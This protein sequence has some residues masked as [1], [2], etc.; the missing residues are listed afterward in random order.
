M[1]VKLLLA[2]GLAGAILFYFPSCSKESADR[3]AGACDTTNVSYAQI[4]SI[5][6]SNCY[7][8][9]NGANS[10]SGIDLTTYDDLRVQVDN[11]DL[12][13]AVSHTGNVT[14]MPYQLPMLPSCEVNTIA[15]W[16]HQ[17][18]PNN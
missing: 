7:V 12:V 8:C 2:M 11:G 6:Q 15:A 9:H 10:F 5:L 4:V 16:V 1:K 13:N 3:L 17:G 18:A 14:P